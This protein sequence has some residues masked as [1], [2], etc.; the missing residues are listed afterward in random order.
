[1]VKPRVPAP[2]A[3]FELLTKHDLHDLADRLLVQEA[4]AIEQCVQFVLAET[5]G[6]WHGRARA[7]M[8]RRLKH[9]A[10]GRTHRTLLVAT[11]TDRLAT[12]MFSE[13]F[14]D[15]LRLAMHLDFEQTAVACRNITACPRKLYIRRYAEWVLMPERLQFFGPRAQ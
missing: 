12:G 1:M 3:E 7:M 11:I 10:L 8:C 5:R 4:E 6:H 9:C 13:Q 15:Q 2:H 14:K